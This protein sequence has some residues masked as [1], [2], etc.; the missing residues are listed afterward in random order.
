MTD[1]NF[2]PYGR[3]SI[4]QDDIDAVIG[5][6]KSDWLTQGPKIEEFENAVAE[7]CGAKYAVAVSNATAGLHIACMAAGPGEGGL[8]WT[9]PNTF[10]ASANCGRYCGAGVDFVDIDPHTYNMS[11]QAL[12][13]KLKEAERENKLPDV[14]VPVN[15]SGQ[16]CDM[17][18]IQELSR[19]YGFKIIED[20][21]H[22]IGGKYKGEPIGSCKYSDF[23]VFSFHPVKIIATGE[24]GMVLTNSEELYAKLKLFRSHG[25]T[26]ESELLSDNHGP[27]YYEQLEL[28]FNY[29]ITDI[30][31]ALGVSQ[32]KK[33]DE[34]V[35]R[36]HELARLYDE[37]LKDLPLILPTRTD[38]SFSAL[39]L[40]VIRLKTDVIK[41]SRRE[42]FEQMRKAGIGV[43]VHYIPVHLQPYYRKLGF[44]RG[45]FPEAEN[46]YENALTIPLFYGMTEDQQDRVV[47]V[48]RGVVL[49]EV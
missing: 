17:E 9:S 30:Q 32:L 22:A 23:T 33:V 16:S 11:V 20:A 7:Y 1:L 21:S 13:L 10:V 14:V 8:L 4:G 31:A 15:F 38:D 37:K 46:Y 47:D 44:Q 43:N 39:H 26:R 18:G 45:D 41:K 2:I 49:S 35:A 40:Y 28:G 27:W 5:V 48:L 19:K 6:L 24:G 3:Q 29:R 12:A 34:F 42:V 36:R 25:V